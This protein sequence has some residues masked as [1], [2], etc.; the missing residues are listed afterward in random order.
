MPS[1]AGQP[2]IRSSVGGMLVRCR[3]CWRITAMVFLAIMVIEAAILVPSY[4]NY[5]R[6]RLASVFDAA[7]AAVDAGY[8]IA[9]RPG[10]ESDGMRAA[11]T[12]L[13]GT[14]GL[15]GL[16]IVDPH[17]GLV[18]AVGRLSEAPVVPALG[19]GTGIRQIDRSSAAATRAFGA[20]PGY[21]LVL[22]VDTPFLSG[23][24]K[25]FLVRIGG[26]I[27][28][29]SLVVTVATMFVL[30]GVV[31]ERLVQLAHNISLA[32]RKPER[33]QEHQTP[34]GRPDELGI[35]TSN[36]NSLLISTSVALAAV[37]EREERLVGLNRTLE[38]RVQE[39]TAELSDAKIAAETASNA[40][41]AF[42]ANMS[43]E[44]RTPLNAIIGFSQLLT[45][46]ED[47]VFTDDRYREY[48]VDI[49]KSG[50]HLLALI[51]DLLDISRIEA[52]RFELSE[53]EVD[54]DR[55]IGDVM[56]LVSLQAREKDIALT[57]SDSRAASMLLADSRVLKQIVLNLVANAV[58]FTPRGGQIR[59][60]V[61]VSAAGDIG[62]AVID[63]GIGIADD[64]LEM[65]FEPFGQVASHLA[66]EHQGAG[67]GLPLSKRLL[68]LHGG[69]LE[70]RS[71]LG[72]GTR[73]TAWL[74]ASRRLRKARIS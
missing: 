4:R 36:V 20:L 56:S 21:R 17:G 2:D 13:M 45:S 8:E 55:M 6:D 3:L 49:C 9:G 24:L 69:T 41:S 51:N 47:D 25:R 61:R 60:E 42:L 73:A 35:L 22:D 59:T 40:K 38:Q 52:G 64:K 63:T 58:K 30:R 68:E 26:L 39:R 34:A 54:I 10:L 74:P 57:V 71:T 67:L 66:R 70:I 28:V 23:D 62:I 12:A 11:A 27:A 7:S 16:A 46:D 29:I 19:Q 15:R 44:L 32:T 33:A 1:P 53:E 37:R 14:A 50:E 65:V 43:H 72:K 5:E 18:L 48:V 31:L